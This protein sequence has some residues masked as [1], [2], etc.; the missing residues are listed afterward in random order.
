[1]KD[2]EGLKD[3]KQKKTKNKKREG[4]T[5]EEGDPRI[6]RRR[7]TGQPAGGSITQS[8]CVVPTLIPGPTLWVMNTPCDKWANRN[9]GS[10][11]GGHI[12]TPA[13]R[14]DTTWCLETEDGAERVRVGLGERENEERVPVG[15]TRWSQYPSGHIS[16]A[17]E[18]KIR[19]NVCV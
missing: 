7:M 15:L 17:A 6:P 2:T 10:V 18:A 16:G 12:C 1:M 4:G 3:G 5:R 19:C 9:S 14:R 8:G 13:D 11:V